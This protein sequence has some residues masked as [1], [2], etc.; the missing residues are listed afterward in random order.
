MRC[1]SASNEFLPSASN[2]TI[3]PSSTA[4]TWS[5][6][7]WIMWMSGYCDVTSRP[8]RVMSLVSPV[9]IS[10]RQRIPSSL[11]SNHQSSSSN[12]CQPPSA[13][14][15]WNRRGD[16]INGASCALARNASQSVRVFTKWNSRPG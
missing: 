16:S 6:S 9:V 8:V 13:S 15:G 11:G 3:S 12:A 1:C 5:T 7:S 10:A 2:A 4:F 14:I